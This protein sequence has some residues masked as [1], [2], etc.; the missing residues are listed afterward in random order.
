MSAMKKILATLV[1]AVVIA[2]GGMAV[3]SAAESPK[4]STPPSTATAKP[5]APAQKATLG[6]RI[7][8]F[9][10]STAA[11]TIGI[12]PADLRSQMKGGHSI[13][14]V[15]TAH[16]VDPQKVIDAIVSGADTKIQAAVTSGKISSTEGTNLEKLV[17]TNA[18]KLVNATPKQLA[19]AQLVAAA[20]T[21][22]AKTIGITP[23]A[24]RQALASGQ[25]VAQVA[26]AHSVSP[27]TVVNALVTA[28]NTRI[29]TA[30]A[31]HHLSTARA[32]KLKARLPKAAQRFV[33]ATRHGAKQPAA[34]TATATA[35]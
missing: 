8:R 13:A 12:S 24:L 15:A 32:A 35:A 26:T 18:P 9:A 21:I 28:G 25:S 34:A 14:D 29:D 31:N 10:F 1:T 16:K 2:A 20:V 30:V 7:R 11:K 33:D 3:A 6:T 5:N 27:T 23:Q 19:R 17:A 22:S 4:T